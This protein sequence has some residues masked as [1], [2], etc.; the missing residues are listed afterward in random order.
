LNERYAT[1]Y[2]VDKSLLNLVLKGLGERIRDGNF[3][4]INKMKAKE[5]VISLYS[6]SKIKEKTITIKI[7]EKLANFEILSQVPETSLL[8]L[9]LSI[10]QINSAKCT[11][12]AAN[13]VRLI[14]QGRLSQNYKQKLGIIYEFF[15]RSKLLDSHSN[16]ELCNHL[17]ELPFKIM[18][19]FDFVQYCYC[20][21]KYQRPS[22]QIISVWFKI[23]EDFQ[24]REKENLFTVL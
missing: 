20:L 1:E 17:L 14:I 11:A 4:E 18:N 12:V 15:Y 23:L 13:I 6:L 16:K 9:T 10:T 2:G 21:R 24:N 22:L 5:L 7:L 3:E 8:P 19:T